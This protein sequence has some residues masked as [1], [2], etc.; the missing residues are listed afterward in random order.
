M[1]LLVTFVH[2]MICVT[3]SKLARHVPKNVLRNILLINNV[4]NLRDQRVFCSKVTGPP[5]SLVLEQGTCWRNFAPF[6]S[7]F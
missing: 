1:T 5:Y 2:I 7:D 3:S 6:L 4:N